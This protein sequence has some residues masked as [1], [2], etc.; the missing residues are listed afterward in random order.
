[1]CQALNAPEN[2]I[3]ISSL[4]S[5]KR[6]NAMRFGVDPQRGK[7]ILE[8]K[9][10]L[11]NSNTHY[12]LMICWCLSE[13]KAKQKGKFS[14]FSYFKREKKIPVP[15]WHINWL[16]LLCVFQVSALT[17]LLMTN[18]SLGQEKQVFCMNKVMMTEELEWDHKIKC[19]HSFGK[20]CYETFI[21]TYN[22][23]EVICLFALNL[24][25][26]P[27]RVLNSHINFISGRKMSN[28]IP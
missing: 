26:C 17:L 20:R 5:L 7:L 15:F 14:T 16:I 2:K 9:C 6:C 4:C 23:E 13:S 10:H 25:I 28:R 22:T 11:G 1:M 3:S 21:T 24:C 27:P 12:C 19:H 18:C 8:L